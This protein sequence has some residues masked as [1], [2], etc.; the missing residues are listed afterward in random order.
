MAL[1][2][3]LCVRFGPCKVCAHLGDVC[4]S[5]AMASQ[6]TKPKPAGLT[7][8]KEEAVVLAKCQQAAMLRGAIYTAGFLGVSAMCK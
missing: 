3:A 2:V 5:A 1:L 4:D 8:T 6:G 7:P